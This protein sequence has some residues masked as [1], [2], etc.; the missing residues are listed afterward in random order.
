[1]EQGQFFG[2]HWLW[3]SF[4]VALMLSFIFFPNLIRKPKDEKETALDILN[5]RLAKGEISAE[6]YQEKKKIL[7]GNDTI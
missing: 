1:M 7:S 6:E 3:W 4:W 5:K 2:M